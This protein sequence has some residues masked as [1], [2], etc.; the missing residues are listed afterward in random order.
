MAWYFVK[1]PDEGSNSFVI[2][3]YV[4]NRFGV[5]ES[6]TIPTDHSLVVEMPDS[7][8]DNL[9]LYDFNNGKRHRA[10]IFPETLV[11]MVGPDDTGRYVI[12]YT[13]EQL[14]SRADLFKFVASNVFAPDMLMRGVIDEATYHDLLRQISLINIDTD[15][16]Q[17]IQDNMYYD[18]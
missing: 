16:K 3:R 11:N 4:E 6:D 10:R 14:A 5:V 18:L 7:V 12:T 9:Y 2:R 13:D 8:K 15:V 1:A 17:F